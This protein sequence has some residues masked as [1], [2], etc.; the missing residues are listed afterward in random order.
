MAKLKGMLQ[1]TGNL[2]GISF[3]EMDGKIIVRKTSGFTGSAI[4][5]QDNYVR[6]R[7]NATEFGHCTIVGKQ[8]RQALALYIK[9]CKT[10]DVHS[11]LVGVLSKIMK[12]DKVSERGKRTVALGLG[13]PEG[14]QL[15]N[16]FECNPG[17]PLHHMV[18][19]PYH[20]LMAEG[21]IVFDPFAPEAVIFPVAA[22]HLCLQ[23]LILRCDFEN[24]IFTLG[25]GEKVVVSKGN[26]LPGL[27]LVASNPEGNGM[28]IGLVF[29][30]FRQQING[31][32]YALEGCG[33]KVVGVG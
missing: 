25:E 9:K 17:V 12:C 30:E 5:T 22:T 24:G 3:Y 20:V 19:T 15:L 29:G 8:L 26:T 2:D 18:A 11:R 21:K 33:L 16:G 31:E 27:E 28:V 10:P 7:E 32:I 1:F 23:F 6:T 4:K 14:K 13:T